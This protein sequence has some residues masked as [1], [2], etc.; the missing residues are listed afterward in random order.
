MR[1]SILTLLSSLVYRAVAFT[2]YPLFSQEPLDPT[3][4]RPQSIAIIGA[5]IAGAEA[6]FQLAR[7]AGPS[8]QYSVTIFE[9][10]NH[11]GGRIKAVAV[12][13]NPR[14]TVETGATYL[15]AE[16]WCVSKAI[17]QV[18]LEISRP[19]PHLL[20]R[21]VAVWNGENLRTVSHCD[22]KASSWSDL[23]RYGLS[24]WR[25][26]RAVREASDH[27]RSFG[28]LRLF[29]NI[30]RELEE[31]GLDRLLSE[32]ATQ[33]IQDMQLD[34][35]YAAEFIDPCT[36]ARFFQDTS[37]THSLAALMGTQV[38]R[39]GSVKG[40]NLRLIERLVKLSDS[41]LR[42]K[43]EVVRISLGTKRRY[44]LTYS[45]SG[46]SLP[47]IHEAEE[48]DTV[49]LATPLQNSNIDLGG[50]GVRHDSMLPRYS[51][52]HVTHFL[53][54][55]TLS[56]AFFNLPLGSKLTDDLLI[57]SEAPVHLGLSSIHRSEFCWI[58]KD[59]CR[60]GQMC[61]QVLCENMYRVTSKTRI[62]DYDIL[63][64]V[65]EGSSQKPHVNDHKM[66]WVHRE[67]WAHGV[68]H[69]QTRKALLEE[70]QIAPGF[71]YLN[72]AE[73]VMPSMEMSCR[74][75]KIAAERIYYGL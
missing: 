25:Y 70:V 16:D 22:S 55:S 57:S 75:G 69:H 45:A 56:P 38:P 17:E 14:S 58:D 44:K 32:P 59:G 24:S 72:S 62:E 9:R 26:H 30:T 15:Y 54:S 8:P 53:T 34:P 51:E 61:D 5:G 42:L 2:Q 67:N 12:P 10:E 49:I 13:Q 36:R 43:S 1:F 47:K 31:H 60:P 41:A 4:T 39:L 35:R 11:V 71:Y 20:P 52:V 40:G 7:L 18:G 66:N 65:G 33:F 6:A 19:N 23:R 63:A 46:T 37:D 68:L 29:Q 73:E 21:T 48:F 27:W 28:S 64:M 74:M 3:D 50:L